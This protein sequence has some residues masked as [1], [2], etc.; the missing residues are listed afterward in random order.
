MKRSR[1]AL[2]CASVL[3]AAL[4][5]GCGGGGGDEADNYVSV[6]QFETGGAGFFLNGVGA[7]MRI[8]STGVGENSDVVGGGVA[9]GD[10]PLPEK[11]WHDGSTAGTVNEG[12]P[13]GW[14][15]SKAVAKQSKVLSGELTINNTRVA[16]I[17]AMSYLME[18]GHERAY[19]TL[20]Y[21][22]ASSEAVFTTQMANFFGYISTTAVSSSTGNNGGNVWVDTEGS[23]RVVLPA[24]AGTSIRV[25][26]TFTNGTAVVQLIGAKHYEVRDPDTG[27]KLDDM[28]RPDAIITGENLYFYK[29]VN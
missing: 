22:A 25:W 13:E 3:A 24:A 23:Q 5:S 17:T 9:R 12:R 26:L 19:L 21:E 28:V 10:I 7:S 6:T 29:I 11:V 16:H 18:E 8:V 27:D 15:T 14:E 2:A 1:Y 4:I 20:Y